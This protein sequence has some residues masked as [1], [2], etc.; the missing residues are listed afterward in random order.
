M[1]RRRRRTTNAEYLAFVLRI[2]RA[3]SIRAGQD[4]AALHDLNQLAAAVQE[5]LAIA[6]IEQRANGRSWAQIAKP[7]EVS[8]QAAQ[9]RFGVYEAT[10]P[11][12][13]PT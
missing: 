8:R 2:L 3:Y 1:P 13:Q 5:S 6:V 11:G 7:L 12:R 10:S 9:M 4:D